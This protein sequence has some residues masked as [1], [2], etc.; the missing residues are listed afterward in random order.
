[1]APIL[2]LLDTVAHLLSS[3]VCKNFY[4][5]GH[6]KFLFLTQNICK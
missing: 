3:K 4:V 2:E 6:K 1:M 5:Y